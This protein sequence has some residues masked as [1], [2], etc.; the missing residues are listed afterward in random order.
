MIE[1][2]TLKNL[3]DA[4]NFLFKLSEEFQAA[5]D[6]RRQQIGK[7]L[8]ELGLCIESV[9]MDLEHNQF[10]YASCAKMGYM[11]DNFMEIVSNSVDRNKKQELFAMLDNARNIEQL[12]SEFKQLDYAE[13]DDNIVKLKQIAGTLQGAGSVLA[14]S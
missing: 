7:W 4:V 9:A 2:L 13:K 6:H 8:V 10:P 1:L 3:Y 14:S 11:V 5:D 12:F